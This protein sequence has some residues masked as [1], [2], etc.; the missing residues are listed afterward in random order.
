M[1]NK[2]IDEAL[3]TGGLNPLEIFDPTWVL[4]FSSL[5][6]FDYSLYYSACSSYGSI[7]TC[8]FTNLSKRMRKG[9]DGYRNQRLNGT[10]TKACLFSL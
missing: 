10:T 7:C 3:C 9:K 5:F 6:P 8:S 2:R 4:F 1:F